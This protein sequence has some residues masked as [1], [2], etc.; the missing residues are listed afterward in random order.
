MYLLKHFLIVFNSFIILFFFIISYKLLWVL[1]GFWCSWH[2]KMIYFLDIYKYYL[3]FP[4]LYL[5][6]KWENLKFNSFVMAIF[7]ILFYNALLP[8]M[9]ILIRIRINLGPWIRIQEYKVKD[10]SRVKPTIF[11]FLAG[12]GTKMLSRLYRKLY[13]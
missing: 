5:D 11:F 4:K 10:K 7:F 9:W 13:F 8:G 12:I 3:D 1:F 6:C 2:C